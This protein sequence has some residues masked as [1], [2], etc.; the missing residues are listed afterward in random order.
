MDIREQIERLSDLES[1]ERTLG[2]HEAADDALMWRTT[3]ERLRS[4]INRAFD[5]YTD[6]AD[7]DERA[8]KMWDILGEGVSE[9]LVSGTPEPESPLLKRP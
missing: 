5:V 1:Q 8:R 6:E 2:N 9:D 7:P 3:M 4:I